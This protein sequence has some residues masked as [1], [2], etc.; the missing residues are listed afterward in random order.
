MSGTGSCTVGSNH[1]QLE[2][3]ATGGVYST[4]ASTLIGIQYETC[5]ASGSPDSPALRLPPRVEA[6]LLCFPPSEVLSWPPKG[7]R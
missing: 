1:E 4:T 2:V 5:D 3:T 7:F 6:G